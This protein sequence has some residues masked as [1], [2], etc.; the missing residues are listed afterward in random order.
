MSLLQ[1]SQLDVHIASTQVCNNLNINCKPGEIWGILGRNGKGKTTLLHSFAGLYPIHGGKIFLQQKEI[2]DLSRRQIAQQLGVLL[3][4]HEDSFPANVIETVLTGRHPHINHWQWESKHDFKLAH[5]A[6]ETVQL[7]HLKHRLINQL[8]GG[9]RQRV[10]IATLITQNPR[11]MLMDEPNSHLD[12]KYQIQLLQTLCQQ[13]RTQQ[14]TIIMTLHDLNLAARFCDKL[15]LLM[16]EGETITGNT[17]TL[18]NEENLHRLYD[19]PVS[20]FDTDNYPMFVA[21]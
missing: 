10:A 15:I 4:H 20:R 3:Q 7:S 9:E 17:N 19:Y 16:G 8:S 5:D 6:L 18:L 1:T 13:A 14:K 2:Q 11:L 12:L 21:K